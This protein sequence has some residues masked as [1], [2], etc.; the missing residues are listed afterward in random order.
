MYKDAIRSAWVEINLSNLDYNIK[1]IKAKVGNHADIIGV[2]KADGYG[3]G[4]VQTAEVLRRNGV[5]TFAVAALSE[6]IKLRESGAGE[7]IIILGL[8][9]DLY[10][11][12]LITYDLTPVVCSASNAQAISQAAKNAGKT[13]EGL[14]AI[15]TGMGR[16]GYLPQDPDTIGDIKRIDSLEHFKIKGIFS[17]FATA[18]ASD[19]TYA[20]EQ[21]RRYNDFCAKLTAAG[22]KVP[23]RTFANSA[24]V[25]ELPS[26]YYD[27]VRPGIIL[28]GCYPSAE[29]D[30]SQL[31]IKPAMSVKANIIHLKKVPEGTTIS[32]GRA[33]TAARESLIATLALGYADGLPRPYSQVGKVIVNGM[34]APIAG[35][36]CMDQCMVDVT[37]V[38]DV[39]LGDEV[40]I[41][42]SDGQNTILADDIGDATGTINYEIVCA[43]GQ[44]LPKVYIE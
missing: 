41:M 34:L 38:P 19:K 13:V 21:E 24:S 42:G 9:P 20:K 23:M 16:I 36:I 28:Y 33:F 26:V 14:V 8:T 1:N 22:V 44:R 7:E 29:V 43:F 25:M 40:I 3:H 32:Y 27:A 6:A 31:S 10:A 37:D 17:H 2:I 11:D 12:T 30:K 4:S 15:D 18:D 5:K 39:K 35:N